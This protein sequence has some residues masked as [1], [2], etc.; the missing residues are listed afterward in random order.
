MAYPISSDA[1]SV[2]MLSRVNYT[3][4]VIIITPVGSISSR[5]I[6]FAIDEKIIF[7]PKHEHEFPVI[8]CKLGFNKSKC[9]SP[10]LDNH[11]TLV[12]FHITATIT[13]Q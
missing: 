10:R 8:I 13:Y 6:P 9:Q 5:A 3:F 12:R 11:S 2:F 4:A 7:L 1:S